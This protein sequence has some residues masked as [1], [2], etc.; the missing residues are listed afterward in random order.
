MVCAS[1]WLVFSRSSL[2]AHHPSI[3]RSAPFLSSLTLTWPCGKSWGHQDAQGTE[4]QPSRLHRPFPNRIGWIGLRASVSLS[5]LPKSPRRDILVAR[6]RSITLPDWP[7][8]SPM[9]SL[10]RCCLPT[11]RR[12]RPSFTTNPLHIAV[13]VACCSDAVARGGSKSSRKSGWLLQTVFQPYYPM[14]L[15][16][17]RRGP[18]CSSASSVACAGL[19]DDD[20]CAH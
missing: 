19:T 2:L 10:S 16:S 20:S 5:D 6:E 3:W 9:C 4:P 11:R 13:P 8:R 1:S 7:H 12:R 15:C 14:P 17:H 18:F